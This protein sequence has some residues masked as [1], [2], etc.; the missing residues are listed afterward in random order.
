M[1]NIVQYNKYVQDKFM[2]KTSKKKK[3]EL[4]WAY[5]DKTCSFAR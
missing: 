5:R 3:E 1:D 2:P 4:E